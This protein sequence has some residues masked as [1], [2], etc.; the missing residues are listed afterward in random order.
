MYP[1]PEIDFDPNKK[2]Y[3]KWINREN[4]FSKDFNFEY[5]TTSY[6]SYLRR[7]ESSFELLNSIDGNNI[8]RV[9]PHTL[10]CNTTFKDK[11]MTHNDEIVFY[12]DNHH[13]SLKGSYLINELIMKE[14]NK[15]ELAF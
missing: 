8:Y 11:C 13:P 1:I 9:Y 15:I 5:I 4:K 14:I 7:V 2:I 12:I 3:L 6:K 10:F